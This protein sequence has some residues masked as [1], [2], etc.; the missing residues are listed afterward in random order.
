L[1]E[2]KQHFE[3]FLHNQHISDAII[4]YLVF[5]VLLIVA[6]LFLFVSVFVTKKILENVVGRF[7]KKTPENGMTF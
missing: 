4:P 2:L 1:K 7:F 5:M 3:A 6:G